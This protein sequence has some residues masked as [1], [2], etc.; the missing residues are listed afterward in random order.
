MPVSVVCRCKT[1]GL[2]T[3]RV[4]GAAARLLRALGE[5]DAELTVSLV[6]DA[7]I[8][9]LNR[10]Y[11]GEDKPTDVL[12]FAM[13][14]GPRAPGD[15]TMLGDVVISLETAA[16]QARRCRVSTMDA[17]RTLL[18]HGILHLLG[19]DHVRSRAAAR[20]MMARERELRHALGCRSRA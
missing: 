7:E 10:A 17:L 16:R 8:Q 3:A 13:R 6:G 18:I 20:R 4:G 2:R 14:E 15:Q 19:Y 12:A 11:R 1:R 9:Q 5:A